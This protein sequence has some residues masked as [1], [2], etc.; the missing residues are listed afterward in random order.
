MITIR[1]ESDQ[2]LRP[3]SKITL[4]RIFETSKDLKTDLSIAFS[5]GFTKFDI[6]RFTLTLG[7]GSRVISFI[8]IK[9]FTKEAMANPERII[10]NIRDE[11][12]Y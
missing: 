11:V 9:G 6:D 8:N 3:T 1:I 2:S 7:K 12:D 5:K 10:K 4:K